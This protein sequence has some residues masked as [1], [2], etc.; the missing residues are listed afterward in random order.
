M[1]LRG[2][3]CIVGYV[4]R[5][6][7][8]K[9]T[10]VATLTLEQWADLAADALGDAGIASGEVDGIVCAGDIGETSNFVP[11]TI[12]E[13]CGWSVNLAERV[14]LGGASSVGM[15]WRAAAAIELGV[16]EVVVMATPAAPSPPSPTPPRADERILYGA[17]S[18]NWGSPQ[19]E[20]EIPYGNVAQNCG[21]AM[22][23]QRYHDLYG[24][25]ERA[26]AKLVVDQRTSACANPDA[27]FFGTPLTVDDVLA[28]RV[29]A[30][31][32]HLLE[33]VMPCYGGA[34]MVLCSADRAR[35]TPHRPVHVTGF[36]ERLTH[37]T[38]TYS[39]DLPHTPVAAA[40]ASAFAMA[41]LTP[42]EVDMAQ[43]Y[44]CYS[45]TALLTLEDSGFCGPGEGQAFVTEHDLSYRGEFPCNTHGGQLGFGQPR[46]AGGMSHVVEGVRQIQG[47]AA[48]RQVSRHDN[49]YVT[50]TGGVMS[51]QSAV[52]LQGA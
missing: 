51:E 5:R 44:D 9:F 45:I 40:A 15:V 34:A 1:G 52:V 20:F 18:N 41:G 47:R 10:G 17:S 48:D 13:Y 35:H 29:I 37:K 16:C 25:D 32:L 11:A 22:Y 28:S 6:S 38:P 23:A 24:W 7:E 49:A 4:E 42:A 21:F 14:D 43:V 33:I 12:A 50:G 46:L 26:R 27:V 31:P 19:A 36:G 2:D 3:A 30:T 8:R 39:P